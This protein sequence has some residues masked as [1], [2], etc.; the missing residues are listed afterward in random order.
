MLR[1]INLGPARRV[2]MPELRALLAGAGYTDVAT[3][4]QSGNIVLSGDEPLEQLEP[5]VAALIE[6]HFG[7]EVPV[8][9]RSAQ[10]LAAVLA[11]DPIRGAAQD[12]K[13]YQV[14]F[15]ALEPAADVVAG[16][17]ER[18]G[19]TECVVAH[20]REL[21]SWHPDGIARSK[22][23]TSLTAKALGASATARNWTTVT[24]LVEMASRP[25]A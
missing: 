20:G 18:A 4:V 8:I 19:E 15:L 11:H 17:A 25:S 12:P 13:H 9:G 10:Q 21:Y 6:D 22:L 14:T 3:Y 5:A 7:F 2:P 16:L 1:G 23:A 24:M